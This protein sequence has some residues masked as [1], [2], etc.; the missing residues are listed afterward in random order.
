MRVTAIATDIEGSSG[1][2]VGDFAP[3]LHPAAPRARVA[4][5]CPTREV[6][7]MGVRSALE[8]AFGV[9]L[10][11][12]DFD[13]FL[14]PSVGIEFVLMQRAMLGQEI[15]MSRGRSSPAEEAELIAAV[16]RSALSWRDAVWVAEL[17]RTGRAPDAMVGVTPRLEPVDW[18]CNRHGWFG[19]CVDLADPRQRREVGVPVGECWPARWRRSRRTGFETRQPSDYVP[20]RWVPGADKIAQ[21]RRSYLRWRGALDAVGHRLRGVDLRWVAINDELPPARPWREGD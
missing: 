2:A 13:E 19:K 4:D 21:A 1:H 6:R 12:L 16:V 18:T 17:A 11:G 7:R 3:R 10:A 8:W 14:Q 9:E 20:C 15:D 5:R